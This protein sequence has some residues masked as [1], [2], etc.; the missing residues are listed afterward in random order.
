[1]DWFGNNSSSPEMVFVPSLHSNFIITGSQ[2]REV[3]KW[4]KWYMIRRVVRSFSSDFLVLFCRNLLASRC[5]FKPAWGWSFLGLFK[6]C[7]EDFC[8]HVLD[9]EGTEEQAKSAIKNQILER[10]YT[11][12]CLFSTTCFSSE[13]MLTLRWFKS[14]F[15]LL[16]AFFSVLFI[17]YFYRKL[18]LSVYLAFL[19]NHRCTHFKCQ[20]VSFFFRFSSR[21]AQ[22]SWNDDLFNT[23]LFCFNLFTMFRKG[24]FCERSAISWRWR[25]VQMQGW[26]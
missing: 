19:S 15:L 17:K 3:A 12:K 13:N 22:G 18:S 21:M 1:M 20:T 2:T 14:V 7:T 9:R 23:S 16:N 24:S 11:L 4:P 10:Y 6:S 5:C 8:N 26:D 25:E